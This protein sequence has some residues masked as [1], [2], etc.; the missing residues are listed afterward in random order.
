MRHGSSEKIIL[1]L[2]EGK[3]CRSLNNADAIAG[4]EQVI[5]EVE[6]IRAGEE[7]LGIGVHGPAV[8][9]YDDI[10]AGPTS[11]DV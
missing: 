1:E 4:A 6:R 8:V 7:I 5:V 11:R 2:S 9:D 10:A 3:E